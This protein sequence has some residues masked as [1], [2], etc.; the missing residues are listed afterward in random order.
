MLT[1]EPWP[2]VLVTEA[3]SADGRTLDLALR[4]GRAGRADGLRLRFEHLDPG[5]EYEVAGD[6]LV[7]DAGG[8]G[9]IVVDLTDPIVTRLQPAVAP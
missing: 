1:D 2:D 4:P 8:V 6:R 5:V 9:E 7:A 3:T